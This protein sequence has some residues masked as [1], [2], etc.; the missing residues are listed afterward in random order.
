[1]LYESSALPTD[2]IQNCFK[3]F[4]VNAID[5]LGQTALHR[6]AQNG[7]VSVS[8]VLLQNGADASISSLQ[9]YRASQ[10]CSESIKKI[11]KGNF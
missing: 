4:Q 7:H 9:G 2:F 6:S 10:N 11:L 8:E 5:N 1:M 3:Q